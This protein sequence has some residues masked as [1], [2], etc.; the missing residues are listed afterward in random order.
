MK[1]LIILHTDAPVAV[2]KA[3]PA[4][5]LHAAQVLCCVLARH[6]S[7]GGG[8]PVCAPAGIEEGN[9]AADVTVGD[10]LCITFVDTGDNRIAD[11]RGGCGGWGA[12]TRGGSDLFGGDTAAFVEEQVAFIKFAALEGTSG[13][14]PGFRF[15]SVTDGGDIDIWG[16]ISADDGLVAEV[17]WV[18]GR[19][20]GVRSRLDVYCS[21]PKS[22]AFT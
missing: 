14:V 19:C 10:N 15:V 12:A 1:G 3:G 5:R 9:F 7:T 21:F 17:G 16:V 2:A 13:V 8:G 22:L 4:D 20:G 6:N 18:G 11:E